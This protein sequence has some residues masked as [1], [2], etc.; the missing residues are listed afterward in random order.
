M[1]IL[2]GI[3]GVS[4]LMGGMGG[5]NLSGATGGNV[6]MGSTFGSTGKLK[7]KPEGGGLMPEYIF[8]G[9]MIL[10]LLYFGLRGR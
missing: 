7:F 4:Q 1:A 5:T 10:A 8:G 9:V 6:G 3:A 2:T